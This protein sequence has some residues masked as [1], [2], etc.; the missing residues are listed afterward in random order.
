MKIEQLKAELHKDLDKACT[1]TDLS[2][3]IRK[4]VEWISP[5]PPPS[6]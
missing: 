2:K 1:I 5:A 4:L 6:K 3:V